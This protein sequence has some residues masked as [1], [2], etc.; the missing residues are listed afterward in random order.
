MNAG[1]RAFRFNIDNYL[2]YNIIL[3]G[4]VIG[5]NIVDLIILDLQEISA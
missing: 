5:E 1:D 2:A 3:I 4:R